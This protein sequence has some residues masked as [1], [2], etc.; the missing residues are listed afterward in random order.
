MQIVKEAQGGRNRRGRNRQIQSEK[1]A[2]VNVNKTKRKGSHTMA[3]R[4]EKKE[5]AEMGR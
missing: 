2:S 1:D 3:E 4:N 5:T